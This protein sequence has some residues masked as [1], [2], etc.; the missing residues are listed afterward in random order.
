MNSDC[1]A[2]SLGL[3]KSFPDRCVNQKPAVHTE[4][5]RELN[6]RHI[7]AHSKITSHFGGRSHLI[8]L[9]YGSSKS[10]AADLFIFE[11][12]SKL[13]IRRRSDAGSI[14]LVMKSSSL[15]YI[16]FFLPKCCSTNT[17]GLP[18]NAHHW[19]NHRAVQRSPAV[20]ALEL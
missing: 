19:Y 4:R 10:T 18:E 3:G 15:R 14:S 16:D 1:H 8:R 20:T 5:V 7:G 11:A 17:A 6:I 13:K 2:E 12:L 9:R